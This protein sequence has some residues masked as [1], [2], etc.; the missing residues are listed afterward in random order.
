VILWPWPQIHVDPVQ[1][2]RQII[3]HVVHGRHPD[4]SVV[5]GT[6][7]TTSFF[8]G[9][10][11]RR[12][13]TSF[14]HMSN[15]LDSG[16]FA[17]QDCDGEGPM[18]RYRIMCGEAEAIGSG[19]KRERGQAGKRARGTVC[20]EVNCEIQRRIFKERVQEVR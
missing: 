18:F 3:D 20:E 12:N 15:P 6:N 2:L 9:G 4:H 17:G 19:G 1:I 11:E 14:Q 7:A 13:P 16:G 8:P 10:A 5:N